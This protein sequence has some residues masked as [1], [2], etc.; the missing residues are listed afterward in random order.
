LSATVG[1]LRQAT[2]GAAVT[3]GTL[4]DTEHGTRGGGTLHAEATTSVAGFL[5]ATDKTKLDA[6]LNATQAANT[7]FAGPPTGAAAVPTFRSIVKADLPSVTAYTDAANVFT[8]N[9]RISRATPQF[10]LDTTSGIADLRFRRNNVDRWFFRMDEATESGGDAG[11]NWQVLSRT[12]AGTTKTTVFH[13]ERA[14]GNVG[15]STTAPTARLDV[16]G[17][18]LARGEA[19]FNT[20]IRNGDLDAT[21]AAGVYAARRTVTGTTTQS[22]M[23]QL[24]HRTSGTPATNFGIQVIQRLQSSTTVDRDASLI[25]TAWSTATDATRAAFLSISVYDFNAEREG[26]RIGASG[27]AATI[28]FLGAAPVVQ[29]TLAAASTDLASVITLANT[30]RTA[31]IN[32]GLGV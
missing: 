24:A 31:L 19:Q 28:G 2:A 26:L 13:M 9:Q 12:D 3:V 20:G 14:T 25:R 6:I 32:F 4:T 5:G 22:Q 1:L 27:T 18:F 17:T 21:L 11:S 16:S 29:Q 7:L 23:I 15:L 30:L 10:L 8:E